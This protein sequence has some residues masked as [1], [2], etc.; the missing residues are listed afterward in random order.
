MPL[1][2]F[3]GLF[4]EPGA[5]FFNLTRDLKPED[6]EI[7]ARHAVIDLAPKLSDFLVTARLVNQL[8]L[9]I[10]CDTSV[11]HLAGGMGKRFGSCFPSR[12]IGVG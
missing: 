9:V 5:Q 12:L 3:A 11:A 6:G 1:D 10:T 4:H 2:L 7:L 8:D